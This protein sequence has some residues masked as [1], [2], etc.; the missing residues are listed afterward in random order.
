M[1]WCEV[2]LTLGKFTRPVHKIG[3]EQSFPL[4][5]I[6]EVHSFPKNKLFHET[7]G[8]KGNQT[9]SNLPIQEVNLEGNWQFLA[10]QFHKAAAQSYALVL[11]PW[12]CPV[13]T[14]HVPDGAHFPKRTNFR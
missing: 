12:G 10:K 8:I 9:E 11:Q 2:F 5:H 1:F 3:F 4:D 14:T 6:L 7:Y 13:K